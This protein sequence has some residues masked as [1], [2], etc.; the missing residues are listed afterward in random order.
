MFHL[1]QPKTTNKMNL[2]KLKKK[3]DE[4]KI[5]QFQTKQIQL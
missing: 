5:L 3:I 1:L 4:K 2:K